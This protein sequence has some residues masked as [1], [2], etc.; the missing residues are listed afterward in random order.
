MMC[1]VLVGMPLLG[2]TTGG[3]TAGNFG[4]GALDCTTAGTGGYEYHL[5]TQKEQAEQ[6]YKDGKIDQKE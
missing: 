4:L 3:T 2:L 5:K 6:D 1:G